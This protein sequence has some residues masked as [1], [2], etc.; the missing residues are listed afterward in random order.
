MLRFESLD[1][2]LREIAAFT[3]MASLSYQKTAASI[4]AV[5]F[6]QLQNNLTI[7]KSS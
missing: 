7:S 3:A 5:V 6:A 2:G 4:L 1:E